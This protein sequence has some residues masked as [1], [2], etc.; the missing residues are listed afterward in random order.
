MAEHTP[1]NDDDCEDQGM[2][3]T[4]VCFKF[5]CNNATLVRRGR[6]W[7]CPRCGYSYGANAH[8]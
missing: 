4:T 8:G 7:R 3:P 2:S 5:G 6:Y 1:H